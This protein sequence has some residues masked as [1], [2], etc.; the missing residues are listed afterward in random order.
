MRRYNAVSFV[1]NGRGFI[2]TGIN[3]SGIADNKVWA[4]DPA[5]G[6]WEELMSFEGSSR[7]QAIAFVLDSRVFVGTGQ[8]GAA[9]YDDIWEFRP[10]QEYNEND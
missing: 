1:M 8:S 9:R 10:D 3:S 2:A 7:S 4:Y 6:F 5:T